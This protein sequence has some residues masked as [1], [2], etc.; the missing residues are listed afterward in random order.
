MK[1]QG[2]R[3]LP[4]WFR[5]PEPQQRSQ[6]SLFTRQTSEVLFELQVSADEC[7]RWHSKGWLS[8]ELNKHKEVDLYDD[9][10][11][12]EVIVVRDVVRSGLSDVQIDALLELLPRPYWLHPDRLAFSFRHGW[13]EPRHLA[14]C[15]PDEVIDEHLGTWLDALDEDELRVLRDQINDRLGESCDPSEGNDQ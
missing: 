13:V 2:E 10:R 4:S 6:R 9:P 8:W 14:E 12:W 7:A 11:I 1:K 3:P 5:A 15:D